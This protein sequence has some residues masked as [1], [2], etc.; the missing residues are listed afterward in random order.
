MSQKQDIKNRLSRWMAEQSSIY[1]Q[2]SVPFDLPIIEQRIIT[3]VQI[4]EL[5]LFLEHLRGEPIHPMQIKPGAFS[6]IDSI[7]QHFFSENQAYA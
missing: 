3:S 4:M 1:Q 7:Y 6:S 5:I 2:D